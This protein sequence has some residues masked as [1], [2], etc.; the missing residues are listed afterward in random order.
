MGVNWVGPSFIS[1]AALTWSADGFGSGGLSLL[2]L[3]LGD[4]LFAPVTL[5]EEALTLRGRQ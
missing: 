4:S 5:L 1:P 3:S 2:A